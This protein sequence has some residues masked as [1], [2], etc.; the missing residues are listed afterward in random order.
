MQMVKSEDNL[1]K[2]ESEI[3]KSLKTEIEGSLQKAESEG[4]PKQNSKKQEKE[5]GLGD[6]N[7]II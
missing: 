7:Y 4:N 5:S 6:V 3:P 1:K 2:A